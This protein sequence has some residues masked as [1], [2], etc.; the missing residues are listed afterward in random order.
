MENASFNAS[1]LTIARQ[2][3]GLTK[4][5]LAQRIGVEPR[6]ISGFEAGQYLPSDDSF[7]RI[8]RALEFPREFF[9][10]DDIEMLSPEGV[11]F[12]SMTKMT[13]KQRDAAIAAGSIALVIS[14]W[15]DREFDLPAADLPDYAGATPEAAALSLRQYWGQGEL[16]ITNMIHLLELKGIRVFSLAENCV[17][18]DAYSVWRGARPFIFLNTGKSGEHRRF[19]AAHE[20]AHLVLHRHAAPNGLEAEKEAHAFAGAFL[21]PTAS[22]KAIGRVFPTLDYIIRLKRKWIVSAAAML[23]RLHEIGMLTYY[24]YNRLFVELGSKG[25]RTNEPFGIKPE[26]SQVWQKVFADLRKQNQGIQILADKLLLPANEVVKLVFGL[27][28]VGLP[29]T[30]AAPA[31]S[32]QKTGHLIV[33]K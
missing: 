22:M 4:K 19:D 25:F 17:E 29:S 20:L 33:I 1:R 14:D 11:S 23:Y 10:A 16:P 13:A 27:A 15:V 21:M 31:G 8:I 2:R 9:E 12:R 7:S 26:T 6:A 30:T 28:T 3:V 18:V 32:A 5:E 24:H